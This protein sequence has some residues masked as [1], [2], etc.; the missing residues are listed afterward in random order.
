MIK[1]IMIYILIVFILITS[2][3][4]VAYASTDRVLLV[5][6]N[7]EEMWIISNL[8]RAC[9]MNPEPVYIV[10]YSNDM[11]Q[12]YE[13]VVLQA[14]EPLEDVLKLGKR[15]VCLGDDFNE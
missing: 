1:K 12:E 8:I 5:Y 11:I 6:D 7:K 15:P 10:E 14:K 4:S 3:Q 2:F 9:G 13:Y